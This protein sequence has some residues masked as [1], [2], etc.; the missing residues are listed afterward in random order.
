MSA[1][2]AGNLRG[3]QV[4]ANRETRRVDTLDVARGLAMLM[5]FLNHG[6]VWLDSG[7]PRALV[8]TIYRASDFCIPM[9]MAISGMTMAYLLQR[10]TRSPSCVRRRYLRRSLYL[11][12][13]GHVLITLGTWPMHWHDQTFTE[14]LLGRWHITDSIAICL[15]LGPLLIGRLSVQQRTILAVILPALCR[16]VTA[17]WDPA[18]PV[19]KGLREF[20]CGIND[21]DPSPVLQNTYPLG[22]YLAMFLLGTVL[23]PFYQAAV[24]DRA[25]VPFLKRL[26][27][28]LLGLFVLGM[29][30]T[31]VYVLY[32]R[33]ALDPAQYEN[34]L[35]FFY[36]SKISAL[37]PVY[38][39]MGG[40]IFL[41]VALWVDLWHRF[42]PLTFSLVVLGRTSF[43]A[44]I[45]QYFLIQ[46][47]PTI[48]DLTHSVRPWQYLPLVVFFTALMFLICYV[49]A[50]SK[51]IISR[52][53][54]RILRERIR[55]LPQLEVMPLTKGVA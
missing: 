42:G 22:P 29:T 40:A 47:V 37:M 55:G 5:V 2:G 45:V 33:T 28:V 25:L 18:S 38:L 6:I 39:A 12:V 35:A 32:L 26:G 3:T 14:L 24:W 50:R 21:L 11:L 48:L 31:L 17:F 46:G 23:G 19:I 44:Y 52:G 30:L 27:V 15:F 16:A 49:Y 34:L 43:F 53:E 8:A 1:E 4:T 10:S 36:P 20:L 54:Y 41:V 51:G 9:F 13:V 7:T